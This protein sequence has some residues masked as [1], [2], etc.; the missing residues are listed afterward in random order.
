MIASVSR[1]LAFPALALII[2]ALLVAPWGGGSGLA[3]NSVTA[4]DQAG[5]VGLYPS[6]E[7]DSSGNPVIAYYR[8]DTGNLKVMHCNDPNCQG[9][10]ESITSPDT[11]G[12]VGLF[13]SLELDAAVNPVVA[14]YDSTNGNLKIMHCNDVNCAGG[15]ESI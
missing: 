7:L 3:D 1:A 12:T 9:G 8:S 10:N 11:G 6:L 2:V 15:N 5:T 14:Y 13:P 4:P